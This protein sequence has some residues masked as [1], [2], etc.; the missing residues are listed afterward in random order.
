MNKKEDKKLQ[1]TNSYIEQKHWRG[2]GLIYKVV[3]SKAPKPPTNDVRYYSGTGYST[4][5]ATL[6]NFNPSGNC[7]FLDIQTGGYIIIDYDLIY[8]MVPEPFES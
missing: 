8:S 3:F 2:E 5:I 1:T 6:E 7:A 4:I